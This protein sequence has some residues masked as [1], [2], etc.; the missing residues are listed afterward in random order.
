M[1]RASRAAGGFVSALGLAALVGL[2]SALAAQD[3]GYRG[4]SLAGSG[5]SVGF[6]SVTGSKPESKLWFHDGSWWGSLWSSTGLAFRIHRLD[7]LTHAWLDTGVTLDARPDSHGDALWD[8]T[9]LY[10]ASHE[11]AVGVGTPGALLL[12]SRFSYATATDTYSLDPGFPATIGDS[13]TE[14]LVIDK[15][16]TGMLWAAWKQASRVHFAHSA[17]SDE[18]WS[19]P[20]ILPGNTS[21]FD[22]DDICS[23]IRFSDKIGVM[24]S[25]QILN[26]FFFSTHQDGAPDTDW[27]PVEEATTDESNDHI[28]LKADSS[29]RV[30]AAVRNGLGEVKLLVRDVAGTWQQHLV[31]TAPEGFARPIALL[32]EQARR[33]HVFATVG[34]T[35]LGGAIHRKSSSLDAIAFAPGQ[36]TIAIQDGSGRVVN[37]PTSTKQNLSSVTGRVV[38]AANLSTAG[39]TWHEEVAGVPAGNGL[40]LAPPSP[41]LPGVLNTFTVTGATPRAVVS[42]F[43]SPRA[44]SRLILPLR[45]PG[46]IPSALGLPRILLRST[47]ANAS[48][49]ATVSVL[50]STTAAG[51]TYHFEALEAASCRVSNKVVQQF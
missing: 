49:V 35:S 21:D 17:G 14:A 40:L 11:F 45:C 43:A 13:A 3:V 15:D 18:V 5:P 19:K 10:F 46:G 30:F 20:A 39:N 50:V 44:G 37:N 23:L 42:F 34:P 51:Q 29:G 25:D 38:L 16:S 24:W 9:K 1:E 33:I 28:H 12:L 48:G 32:D 27:S 26:R 4:P 36:G 7:P 8:G 31:T 2:G 22:T 47:R 6:P 41:G